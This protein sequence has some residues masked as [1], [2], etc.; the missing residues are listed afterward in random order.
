MISTILIYL[1]LKKINEK[2][3]KIIF[4]NSKKKN[5]TIRYYFQYFDIMNFLFTKTIDDNFNY[6]QKKNYFKS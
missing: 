5:L 3:K 6:I 2:K 4:N 1:I